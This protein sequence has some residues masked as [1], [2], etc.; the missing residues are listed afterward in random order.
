MEVKMS[1]SAGV[2]TTTTI[3]LSLFSNKGAVSIHYDIFG[4]GVSF[5]TH[6]CI[7]FIEAFKILMLSI[8]KGSR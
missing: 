8:S 6:S 3:F 1:I 5:K 4:L 7:A 2:K